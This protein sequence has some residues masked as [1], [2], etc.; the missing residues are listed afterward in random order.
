MKSSIKK[1]FAFSEIYSCY[2]FLTHRN[3]S[4]VVY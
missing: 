4:K 3:I 1:I 2:L